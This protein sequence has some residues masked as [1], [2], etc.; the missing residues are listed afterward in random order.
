M[1]DA[2]LTQPS[3]TATETRSEGAPIWYELM[4]PDPAAVRDFYR[5]TL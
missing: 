3:E 2:V 4:V 1:T 5:A